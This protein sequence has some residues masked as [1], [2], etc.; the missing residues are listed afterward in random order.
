MDTQVVH[1]RGVLEP[2]TFSVGPSVDRSRLVEEGQGEPRHLTCVLR[3]VV[4]PLGELDCAATPDVGNA[5]DLS[6]L[7]PVASNVVEDETF[8][9]CQ[10]AER[11]L[12]GAQAPQNRIEQHRTGN[13]EVGASRIQAGHRE[14]LFKVELD[15]FLAQSAELLGGDT[16]VADLR[17]R[18]AACSGRGNGAKT[19]DR[20]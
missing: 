5:V 10:V 7:P 17:R 4:A 14:T 11:Q 1:E 20:S 12:L 15:D 2:L 8:A 13:H 9:E 6:D 18:R 19:Q 16:K 3:K